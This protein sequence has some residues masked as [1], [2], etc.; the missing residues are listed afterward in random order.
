MHIQ[1]YWYYSPIILF[2]LGDSMHKFDPKYIAF[3][4]KVFASYEEIHIDEPVVLIGPWNEVA[5]FVENFYR[6][7]TK[8]LIPIIIINTNVPDDQLWKRI[9]W[10]PIHVYPVRNFSE[11]SKDRDHRLIQMIWRRQECLIREQL[12]C[13]VIE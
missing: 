8:E 12:W 10:F 6:L 1:F 2:I 9:C 7:C 13:W 3:D 5:I 11:I 4:R